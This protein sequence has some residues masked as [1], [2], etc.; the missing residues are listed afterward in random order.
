MGEL[1]PFY[2][3]FPEEQKIFP[4]TRDISWSTAPLKSNSNGYRKES[5]S[6][7][8]RYGQAERDDRGV[9]NLLNVGLA[10]NCGRIFR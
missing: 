2:R 6:L 4:G 10:Q 8:S 7:P 3:H 1:S 9:L 5:N